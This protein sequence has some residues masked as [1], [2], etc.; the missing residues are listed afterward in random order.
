VS[1]AHD[2]RAGVYCAVL[3]EGTVR[4]GDAIMLLD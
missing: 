4:R 2:N 3:T 1:K